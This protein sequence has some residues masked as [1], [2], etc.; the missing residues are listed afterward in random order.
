MRAYAKT[1]RQ[2]P[3]QNG[4]AVTRRANLA[5]GTLL[6]L[7]ADLARSTSPVRESLLSLIAY[8]AQM[9]RGSDCHSAEELFELTENARDLDAISTEVAVLL[10]SYSHA[11]AA[12]NGD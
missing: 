4:P 9:E 7:S 10:R 12:S 1:A 8:V 5:A 3:Q 6:M 11:W 2:R